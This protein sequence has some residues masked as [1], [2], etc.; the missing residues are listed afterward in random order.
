MRHAVWAAVVAL[1]FGAIAMADEDL[2][3][4]NQPAPPFRLP[5]YNPEPNSPTLVGLDRYIGPDASEKGVKAVVVDFMAS[6]CKPC[7]KEMPYLQK[8]QDQYKAQGLRVII[9]SIDKDPEGQKV[10]G[11]LVAQNH[12]TFPVLKDRF[13]LV[14]RRWLGS[15]S[16]LPSV[17]LIRPDGTISTIHRGYDEKTS[18]QLVDEVKAALAAR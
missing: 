7:K 2:A 8:L 5:V 13:N 4:V 17:F 18:A 14:A 3:T 1:L 16:P 15:Q 12:I 9:V 6:Y 10:V 11:D